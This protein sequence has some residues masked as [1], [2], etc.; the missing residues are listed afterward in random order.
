M[1]LCPQRMHLAMSVGKLFVLVMLVLSVGCAVDE[2]DIEDGE[3]MDITAEDMASDSTLGDGGKAD[4]RTA[5]TYA[6]VAQLAKNAGVPCTGER[7]A[8]ATA[9]A[10]AE[11]SHRPWITNTVGNAHGIDRGLWQINSYW[12]PEVSASC[13]LSASCNARAMARIS[14]QGTRWTEWWTWKNNKHVPYMAQART[15]QRGVCP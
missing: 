15:A 3:P 9:V 7:I 12:H 6:Q 8:V 5:L 13:A 14:R 4:G 11:S 10:F 1:V 2:E